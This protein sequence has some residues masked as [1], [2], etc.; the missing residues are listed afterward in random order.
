MKFY[1]LMIKL[2]KCYVANDEPWLRAKTVATSLVY[3]NTRQALLVNV[4]ADEK[5]HWKDLI[6]HKVRCLFD[7]PLDYTEKNTIYINETG[8]YAQIFGNQD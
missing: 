7:R 1:V 8:L 4:D 5:R 6:D 3:K 2:L